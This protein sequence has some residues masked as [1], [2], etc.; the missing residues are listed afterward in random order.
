MGASIILAAIKPHVRVIKKKTK[1]NMVLH[2]VQHYV[3]HWL[4][5]FF[6]TEPQPVLLLLSQSHMD[7]DN[8]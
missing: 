1:Q 7:H 2:L 8:P 6:I 5:C 4:T 3:W